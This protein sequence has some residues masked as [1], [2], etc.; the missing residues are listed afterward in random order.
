M[1]VGVLDAERPGLE[2]YGSGR[3][4][5]LA[6]SMLGVGQDK[7]NVYGYAGVL[8]MMALAVGSFCWLLMLQ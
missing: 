3:R 4:V 1:A 6:S 8:P 5:S 2:T 7:R